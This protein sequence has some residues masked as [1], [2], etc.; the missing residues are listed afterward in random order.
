MSAPPL[1]PCERRYVRA[2]IELDDAHHAVREARRAMP[3]VF[4]ERTRAL[5]ERCFIIAARCS[6]AGLERDCPAVDLIDE[7]ASKEARP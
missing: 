7:M 5:H 2:R 4:G 3:D 6:A 1:T